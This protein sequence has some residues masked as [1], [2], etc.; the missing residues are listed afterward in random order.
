[1][2]AI[3]ASILV[4]AVLL[5]PVLP[6]A[7]VALGATALAVWVAGHQKNLENEWKKGL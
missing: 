3:L 7:S 1:M 6:E 4:Y 5:V 2:K